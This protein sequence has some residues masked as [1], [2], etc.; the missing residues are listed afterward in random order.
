ML[1]VYGLEAGDYDQGEISAAEAAATLKAAGI[2]CLVYTT[3]SNGQPGKGHRWRLLVI[4]EQE[5]HAEGARQYMAILD[6]LFKGV[7]DQSCFTLSQSYYY[8]RHT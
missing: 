8:G 3:P 5:L 1:E 6:G 2:I 7:F 4:A